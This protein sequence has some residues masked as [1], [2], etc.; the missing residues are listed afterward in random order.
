MTMVCCCQCSNIKP[1]GKDKNPE[2]AAPY[3]RL[4]ALFSQ[5][6]RQ[7][8]LEDSIHTLCKTDLSVVSVERQNSSHTESNLNL[9]G[10]E[11]E[12]SL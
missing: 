10:S 1:H 5:V 2:N 11:S 3:A 8:Y 12:P 4:A 6:A 7:S 9:E